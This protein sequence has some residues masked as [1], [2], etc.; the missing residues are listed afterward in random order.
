MAFPHATTSARSIPLLWYR[1]QGLI[2]VMQGPQ[3]G[4]LSQLLQSVLL[5]VGIAAA[6]L[7]LVMKNGKALVCRPQLCPQ[8]SQPW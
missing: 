2:S 4:M 3:D 1:M 6:L 8:L 5:P 7:F